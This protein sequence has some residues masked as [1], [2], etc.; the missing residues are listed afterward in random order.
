MPAV[1]YKVILALTG[2]VA[3]WLRR[4]ALLLPLALLYTWSFPYFEAL[5]NPNELVR[6]YMTMAIVDH[7]TY[8]I[9]EV[10]REHTWVNDRSAVGQRAYSSK[11]PGAS[12]AGVPVYAAVRAIAGLA[13]HELELGEIVL[14]LR[15]FVCVLPALV[16]L[17]FFRR[18]LGSLGA[19][20]FARDAVFVAC[21][22]G[23]PLYTY[24][25]QFAGHTP[26]ACVLFGAYMILAS[27]RERG[28]WDGWRA[29]G[30]GMLLGWAP[31]MEYQA[32]V[33]ALVV[34]IAFLMHGPAR[35][36]GV[37][38]RALAAG[39]IPIGLM[40]HFHTMAFGSPLSTGYAYI[41]NPAFQMLLSEGWMGLTYPRASRIVSLL[42]GPDTG[43]FVFSP[44]L[45]AGLFLVPLWPVLGRT[46]VVNLRSRHIMLVSG[47][48]AATLILFISANILW[49]AGWTAGPRYLTTL[50]PFAGVLALCGL[51]AAERVWGLPVRLLAITA[52]LT[53]I[54]FSGVS[55]A[56]YPHLP[57]TF[58]DPVFEVLVP[59]LRDG[60]VPHNL[61]R[62][63]GLG[64]VWGYV[65]VL[66]FGVAPLVVLLAVRAHE[67]T[68]HKAAVLTCSVVLF[69]LV[70]AV[71]SNQ[72][73]MRPMPLW[74]LDDM[75]AVHS[76][77]EP[78]DHVSLFEKNGCLVPLT[79]Y[80]IECDDPLDSARVEMRLGLKWLAAVHYRRTLAS[81]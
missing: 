73:R 45:A 25:H 41:E 35:R 32:L 52:V 7:A 79:V 56:I 37:L 81:P 55:G 38:W 3:S 28:Q 59:L 49:R 22:V 14:F 48:V 68:V 65:P 63:M 80:R 16:F 58:S 66:V 61:G 8:D 51:Q 12:L 75:L 76:S 9:T 69:V 60:F 30:F 11:A 42:A 34:G 36:A 57:V 18:F 40:A 64:G 24:I 50:V 13:G 31:A 77:W 29:A 62:L 20:P 15:L 46:G 23:S 19:D 43:L 4:N 53:G 10:C 44:L 33:P 1:R 70:L 71:A 26:S 27:A 78:M 39:A 67:S 54:F 21:A 5:N 17:L 72:S 47:L 6:V 74:G 2:A